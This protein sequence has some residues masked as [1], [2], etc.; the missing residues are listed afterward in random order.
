MRK[1]VLLVVLITV[2]LFCTNSLHAQTDSS[3]VRYCTGGCVNNAYGTSYQCVQNNGGGNSCTCTVDCPSGYGAQTG[4]CVDCKNT[5][6]LPPSNVCVNTK[7]T[8]KVVCPAAGCWSTELGCDKDHIGQKKCSANQ[9]QECKQEL[10]NGHFYCGWKLVEDCVSPKKC[11]ELG[12]QAQCAG[13]TDSLLTGGFANS[14]CPLRSCSNTLSKCIAKSDGSGCECIVPTPTPTPTPTP[15]PTPTPKPTPYGFK[16]HCRTAGDFCQDGYCEG[17]CPSTHPNCVRSYVAPYSG[18]CV[19]CNGGIT[20][21]DCLDLNATPTPNP[22]TGT[23]DASSC[24]LKGGCTPPQVCTSKGGVCSC[25]QCTAETCGFL[26]GKC[27]YAQYC[28]L[29]KCKCEFCTEETCDQGKGRCLQGTFCDHSQCKCLPCTL[30]QCGGVPSPGDANSSYVCKSDQ[31]CD[32]TANNTGNPACYCKSPCKCDGSFDCTKC[33]N[34]NGCPGNK[35]CKFFDYALFG[36]DKCLCCPDA[37]SPESD[38]F[39]APSP[40]QL[41]TAGTSFIKARVNLKQDEN[42]QQIPEEKSLKEQTTGE[43]TKCN[44]TS[45]PTCGGTC[46]DPEQVCV[47]KFSKKKN[48]HVCRCKKPKD[49]SSDEDDNPDDEGE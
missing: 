21:P 3:L 1:N 12:Y 16:C 15:V 2:T 4:T 14:T 46:E 19:C 39:V 20:S 44:K 9:V 11:E 8:C 10:K 41:I 27:G 49:T 35:V 26:G 25:E 13:C 17:D 5:S 30:G 45:P 37:N 34:L 6:P 23:G 36:W 42:V 28:D 24:S 7:C 33:L 18:K 22:C 32:A 29:S 43:E 48:K 31:Y 40:G 38:C 47:S